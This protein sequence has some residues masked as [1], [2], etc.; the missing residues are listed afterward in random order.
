VTTPTRVTCA[1]PAQ[2]QAVR[3]ALRPDR[4][5]ARTTVTV[6][7]AAATGLEEL[8]ATDNS[9]TVSLSPDLVLE[10]VRVVRTHR[11]SYQSLVRAQ[12]SGV[13]AG[14]GTLRLRLSGGTVGTGPG[15]VHLSDGPLGADGEGDVECHVSDATGRGVVNGDWATCTRVEAANSGRLF[16]DLRV[17]HPRGPRPVTFTVV[18]VGADEGP[19]GTNNSRTLSLG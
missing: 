10:S 7:V 13:P 19:H 6:R 11:G 8:D 15:Q 16:V 17:A 12:L 2:G 4:P 14:V 3:F 1:Q 18:P 5:A 9:A